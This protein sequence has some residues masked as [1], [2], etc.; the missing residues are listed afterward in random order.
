MASIPGSHYDIFA[1]NQTVNIAVT[2]DPNSVA[3]P[4]PGDFNL[5]VVINST[6]TGS[7]TPAAGYQGLAFLSTDTHTLTA[8]H[9]NF[10][11]VDGGS[12]DLVIL[13]DGSVSIAGASGDTLQGGSGPNQFLDAHLGGQTVILGSGGSE[14]VFGG[15]NTSVSGG[16]N[17]NAT[18][19]GVAGTTVQGS[20][21]GFEFIDATR[22]GMSISGGASNESIWG[23]AGDTIR[24]GS[25]NVTIGGVAG[26]TIVGGSAGN[27]FL[28]GS[29]G[30]QSITGGS[31]GNETI[32]GGPAIRSTA[33][34][35]I[36]SSMEQAATS[37]S[38]PA[39]AIP[40]SGA[41]PMTRSRE[42]REPGRH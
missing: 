27:E 11:I 15:A 36:P 26:D 13:G 2:F 33:A 8:L 32:W 40:R 16:S 17:L 4:V 12:N 42:L 7:G 41:A 31:G 24:A 38:W 19:A 3:P 18:V 9:G 14:T 25:G 30:S 34:P 37:R 1:G 35:P 29:K 6:G 22:G 23:G 28:D 21:S 20:S 5:E 10:G 39:A